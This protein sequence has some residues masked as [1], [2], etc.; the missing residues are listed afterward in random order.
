MVTILDKFSLQFSVSETEDVVYCS[1]DCAEKWIEFG[2]PTKP[3]D[4]TYQSEIFRALQ[5]SDRYRTTIHF[6]S[7]GGSKFDFSDPNRNRFLVSDLPC[8]R[9]RHA[10]LV[11]SIQS[12]HF[13]CAKKWV[14]I[15]V[16]VNG[17]NSTGRSAATR[18]KCEVSV[19]VV[20]LLLANGADVNVFA[21]DGSTPLHHASVCGDIRI[22]KLLLDDTLDACGQSVVF[23]HVHGCGRR[24]QH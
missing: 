24:P 19:D 17:F 21:Q 9:C 22:L 3:E 11:H 18:N 6:L 7:A 2:I 4:L 1:N 5:N 8:H 10:A 12:H 20:K 15:G 14:E 16:P 13:S 23:N